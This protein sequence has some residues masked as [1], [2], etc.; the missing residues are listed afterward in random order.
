MTDQPKRPE[1]APPRPV[2]QT[3]P[4]HG[5]ISRVQQTDATMREQDTARGAE[6]DLRRASRGQ[7]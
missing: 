4:A 5:S 2:K 3:D 1:T 7:R 6:G